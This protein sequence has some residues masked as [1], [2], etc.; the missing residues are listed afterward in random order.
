MYRILG[1]HMCGVA[2]QNCSWLPMFF[3]EIS[4]FKGF[5]ACEYKWM[6]RIVQGRQ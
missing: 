5:V 4:W 2:S 1:S 3:G 6:S